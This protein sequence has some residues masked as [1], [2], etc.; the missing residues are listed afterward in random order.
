MCGRIIPEFGDARVPVE[1]GLD[2]AALHTLAASVYQADRRDAGRR[3]GVDVLGDDGR[4]IGRR[5]GMEVELVFDR[6]SH[7]FGHDNNT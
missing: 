3:G 7:R 1:R 2:D 6:N 4:N 5:E